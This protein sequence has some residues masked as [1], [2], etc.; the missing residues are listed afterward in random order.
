MSGEGEERIA[1]LS[2][3]KKRHESAKKRHKDLRELLDD[4]DWLASE[5]LSKTEII[6]QRY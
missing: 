3:K 1:E 4:R 5:Q 2:F 6:L